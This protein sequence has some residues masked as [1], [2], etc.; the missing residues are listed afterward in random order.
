V[1]TPSGRKDLGKLTKRWR[2]PALTA[3]G[4]LGVTIAHEALQQGSVDAL[5]AMLNHACAFD[6]RRFAIVPNDAER[7][8]VGLVEFDDA[9]LELTDVFDFQPRDPSQRIT[10]VSLTLTPAP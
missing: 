5:L 8:E 2:M 3:R 7:N 9:S 4:A 1:T 6:E 10:A